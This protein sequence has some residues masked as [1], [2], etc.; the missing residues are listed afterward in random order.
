MERLRYGMPEMLNSIEVGEALNVPADDVIAAAAGGQIPLPVWIGSQPRW[1]RLRL[2]KWIQN[3]CPQFP[4]AIPLDKAAA[5]SSAGDR[6]AAGAIAGMQEVYGPPAVEPVTEG[7]PLDLL[8]ADPTE[9]DRDE[10][11]Q[12]GDPGVPGNPWG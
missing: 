12:P 2:L 6:E 3:G 1:P 8:V 11:W 9:L 4:S 7:I 5:E 10:D